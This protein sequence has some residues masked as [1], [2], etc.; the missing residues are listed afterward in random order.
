MN[1]PTQSRR[2]V[3]TPAYPTMINDAGIVKAGHVLKLIDL[4]A[5]QAALD[6]IQDGKRLEIS[7]AAYTGTV[8]VTASVDR[9]SFK[10]PIRTWEFIGLES[11]VTQ[12]WEHSMEVQVHVWAESYLTGRIRD[13]ATSHLVFVGLDPQNRTPAALRAFIPQTEEEQLLAGAADLRRLNRK[14]EGKTAPYVPID[15]TTDNP[16]LYQRLM[17]PVDA[18]AQG[19]VFGGIILDIID[20]AGAMAAQEQ[21]LH[22]PAIGVRLDRMSFIA[23]TF[24]GER[25]EAKSIVTKT[26]LTSLEVQVEVDA[27]HPAN[28]TRRRVAS[29]YLVYVRTNDDGKPAQVPPFD[30]KSPLQIQRAEAAETRRRIRKEEEATLNSP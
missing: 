26:W 14:A 25:V 1:F 30:P 22:Q 7:D 23:P 9:A 5:S 19:N 15:D 21:T 29:C 6:W 10:S 11:R 27:V 3:R 12:V 16:Q 20:K 28:K 4:V 18:N 2:L 17:T 8:V 13:V 24:I